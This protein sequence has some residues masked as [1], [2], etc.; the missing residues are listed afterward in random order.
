[1]NIRMPAV[2][3]QFYP[4][5]GKKLR[6][7]FEEI[8]EKRSGSK[9][10]P[11]EGKQIIG[12]V[13]PHAGYVYSGFHAARFFELL[14][15]SGQDFDTAVVINPNH[16][17][18][19]P[20]IALDPNDAWE[21]P[22]GQVMLDRELTDLL[23]FPQ[24][25]EAH[26]REHS[27]EVMLPFLQYFIRHSFRILPVTMGV[28]STG[29][30]KKIAIEIYKHARD[31]GRKI[32]II[33]SSDFSHFLSPELGHRMDEY[34]L[35]EILALNTEGVATQVNTH[36]VSVCGFGPIMTLMEYSIL[37]CGN[38]KIELL[39]RGHSG[40]VIPS[41]SVV[42]YITLLFYSDRSS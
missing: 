33:A 16:T 15:S 26:D 31:L 11:V 27:G 14:G 17:G 4:A 1:M 3:G 29:N 40:E 34:V 37:T 19:G 39:S 36:D 13:V 10:F 23:P 22:L 32:V 41:R 18:R 12:G 38:P 25:P 8:P 7:Y 28:Q 30:A 2:A 6:E 42:D 5:T 9:V 21:T 24:S 20:E 35:N